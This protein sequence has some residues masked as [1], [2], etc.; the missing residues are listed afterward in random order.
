MS[1]E[2]VEEVRYYSSEVSG[3]KHDN[4]VHYITC[5]ERKS[6]TK[7][8]PDDFNDIYEE[9]LV[10]DI[11]LSIFVWA[12]SNPLGIIY[13]GKYL[14]NISELN[15]VKVYHERCKTLRL[16]KK[17]NSQL[18]KK[19][20]RNN[21]RRGYLKWLTDAENRRRKFFRKQMKTFGKL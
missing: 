11:D 21:R 12:P 1:R 20:K 9:V 17:T 14:L 7:M 15:V 19:R 5:L 13:D 4:V 3:W 6:R 2:L 10:H 8:H 18:K 16:M